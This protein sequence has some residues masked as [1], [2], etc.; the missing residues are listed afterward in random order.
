ML[1]FGIFHWPTLL[2][3]FSYLLGIGMGA[4]IG[5]DYRFKGSSENDL[6]R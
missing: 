3:V 4:L 1:I 5:M 6:Y 2:V